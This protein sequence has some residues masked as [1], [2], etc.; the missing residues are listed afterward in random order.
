[1]IKGLY[2]R[3]LPKRS[4]NKGLYLNLHVIFRNLATTPVT[5]QY[6]ESYNVNGTK[7]SAL[8]FLHINQQRHC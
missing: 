6:F 3:S 8:E 1:M 5:S 4:C 2:T 7:A